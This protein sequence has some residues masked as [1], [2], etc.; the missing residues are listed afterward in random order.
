[1]DN[2]T[3][4]FKL[5]YRPNKQFWISVSLHQLDKSTIT[6]VLNITLIG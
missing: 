5:K 1:M 2:S 6:S 4:I 3:S